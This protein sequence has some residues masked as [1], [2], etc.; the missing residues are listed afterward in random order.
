MPQVFEVLLSA[1]GSLI[2]AFITSVITPLFSTMAS[3]FG[4]SA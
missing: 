1:L 2:N 4:L 3:I